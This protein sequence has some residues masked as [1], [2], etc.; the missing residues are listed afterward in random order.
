MNKRTIIII[1]TTILVSLV[2]LVYTQTS[3]ALDA[4]WKLREQADLPSRS[5][6]SWSSTG[7]MIDERMYHTATLL[8]NDKV[9]VA[10][11]WNG[12]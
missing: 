10:G 9:L 4:T 1:I 2:S 8:P 5:W 6:G 3:S 12:V 7:D 11:G